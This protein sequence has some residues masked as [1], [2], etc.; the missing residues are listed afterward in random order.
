TASL[1]ATGL[2]LSSCRG[3]GDD[4]DLSPT[5]EPEPTPTPVLVTEVPGYEDPTRW[6]GQTLTVTSWGGEYQDAQVR[7]FFEPF[8]R[9]TGATVEIG[10]TDIEALRAEVEAGEASWDVCDVLAEDVLP[11]ANLGAIA[12]IDYS[13]IDR[14]DLLPE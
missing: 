12:P 4:P 14:T 7:A 8:E 3:D 9:L 11:L 5:P 6:E 10:A 1:L 2:A 13:E